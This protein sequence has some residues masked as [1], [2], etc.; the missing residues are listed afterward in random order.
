MRMGLVIYLFQSC[1]KA[2]D[3]HRPFKVIIR[4]GK[5]CDS[6][7]YSSEVKKIVELRGKQ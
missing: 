4:V 7:G 1:V 6:E 2:N 3:L 5:K